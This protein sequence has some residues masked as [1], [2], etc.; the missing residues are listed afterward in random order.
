MSDSA[1]QASSSAPVASFEEAS[2]STRAEQPED[3]RDA[4]EAALPSEEHAV[5]HICFLAKHAS[6]ST[7]VR[8][9]IED[10][11]AELKA[12]SASFFVIGSKY[13]KLM[14]GLYRCC[15]RVQIFL[16]IG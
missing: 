2:L 10:T 4:L 6:T 13:A 14:S 11:I 5:E 15:I 3:D 9:S 8:L 1:A 7:E 12:V 16:Q